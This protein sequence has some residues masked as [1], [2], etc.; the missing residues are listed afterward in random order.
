M[1][2]YKNIFLGSIGRFSP[3]SPK[4][5]EKIRSFWLKSSMSLELSKL[6]PPDKLQNEN[7]DPDLFADTP[8]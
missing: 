5:H 7:L 1:N 6:Q 3:I 4:N 8:I 2:K